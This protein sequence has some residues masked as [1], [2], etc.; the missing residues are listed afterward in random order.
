MQPHET[1][2]G[3]TLDSALA[4][5]DGQIQPLNQAKIPLIDRGFLYG[6]AIFETVRLE[7][8]QPQ[9][10]ALHMARMEHT[11]AQLQMPPI[12]LTELNRQIEQLCKAFYAGGK[13]KPCARGILKMIVTLGTALQPYTPADSSK[14]YLLCYDAPKPRR[15]D[16]ALML[17]SVGVI[18]DNRSPALREYKSTNYLPAF[19]AF[20]MAQD[21]G[22]DDFVYCNEADE[23]TESGTANFIWIDRSLRLNT[24]PA[25]GNAR[26]GVT[27][28][29][30]ESLLQRSGQRI[31]RNGLARQAI[32]T[33]CCGAVLVSSVKL[34][35]PIGAI[36]GSILDHQK[37][38][39]LAKNLNSLLT[40]G[41]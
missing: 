10:L 37:S 35:R 31:E 39:R 24:C 33:N 21:L 41:D 25:K 32:Q 12:N 20:Q 26:E 3:N 7:N 38:I 6:Q 2:L 1:N 16:D 5:I 9:N 40:E 22:F 8:G 13:T 36:D 15:N 27:L 28:E 4:L 11:R 17:L 18:N 14:F 23:L 34:A 30:L 19:L 29:K